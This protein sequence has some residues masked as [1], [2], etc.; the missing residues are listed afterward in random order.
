MKASTI[1]NKFLPN[2]TPN[3]HSVRRKSLNAVLH[4]LILGAQLSVTELGRNID[5]KTSE[6]HQIKRSMRLCSNPH[7]QQELGTMYTLMTQSLI[8]HQPPPLFWLTGRI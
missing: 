2:V 7:L 6:K 1:L 3:M 5:S 8:G 4:S